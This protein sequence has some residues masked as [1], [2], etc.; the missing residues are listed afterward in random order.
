[1]AKRRAMSKMRVRGKLVLITGAGAGIGRSAAI[2]FAERGVNVVA[3]D[4]RPEPLLEVRQAVEALG[5]RCWTYAVDVANDEAMKVLA[6]QVCAEAG[7][8]DV[9]VN[10]A[11]IAYLGRFLESDLAHWPRVLNV[12]VM[13]VVYGCYYFIPKMIAAGGPRRVLIVA[14]AAANYPPPSVAA[15]AASKFAVFGFAE[16]L[17]MELTGTNVG[18][19]TVCPGVINT[20]IVHPSPINVSPA[21]GQEQIDTLA[22][23][24]TKSGA[25]P[26]VVGKAMVRA[27]E[28]GTDMLLTG[29]S[30]RIFFHLRR[31]SLRAARKLTFFMAPKVG[32]LPPKPADR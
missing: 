13:G 7:V 26:D 4:V 14:S 3:T 10:N 22:D 16:V 1:M 17:K 12:N 27:A 19:T 20:A 9:L 6:D 5:V 25:S 29:P 18:V 28:R 8:P 24:Y 23:Y 32:Y 2:A 15:Y 11:G 31:I 30:A 21:V